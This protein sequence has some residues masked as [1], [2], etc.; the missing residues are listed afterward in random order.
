MP[1]ADRMGSAIKSLELSAA[2]CDVT[3]DELIEYAKN[4]VET[5]EYVC[6]GARWD[7]CFLD[8]DFWDAYEIYTGTKVPPKDRG[9]VF[10]C[11]C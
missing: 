6:E 9:G 8:E 3:L 7:G 5:G 11:S 1:V 2:N 10:S 4:F